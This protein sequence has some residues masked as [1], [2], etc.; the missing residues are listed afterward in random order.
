MI[1]ILLCLVQ[2][3][4]TL[5]PAQCVSIGKPFCNIAIVAVVV[6]EEILIDFTWKLYAFAHAD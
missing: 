5:F 6:T 4:P 1:V 3:D 2:V